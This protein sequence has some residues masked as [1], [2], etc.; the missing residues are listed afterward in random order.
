MGDANQE[1]SHEEGV[2]V[3][4]VATGKQKEGEGKTRTKKKKKKKKKKTQ[5]ARRRKHAPK[6]VNRGGG[7][8]S[9]SPKRALHKEPAVGKSGKK[10]KKSE[11]PRCREKKHAQKKSPKK[12][13]TAP[14]NETGGETGVKKIGSPGLEGLL[15]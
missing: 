13:K 9:K 12:E 5:S 6:K 7:L 1:L 15:T 14:K 11:T 10:K 2:K 4:R 8:D 3:K